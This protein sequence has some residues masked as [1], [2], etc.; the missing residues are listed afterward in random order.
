MFSASSLTSF[1]AR[2]G[3]GSMLGGIVGVAATGIAVGVAAKTI[4]DKV[5]S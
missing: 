1:L 3:L 2:V 4:Y 5:K